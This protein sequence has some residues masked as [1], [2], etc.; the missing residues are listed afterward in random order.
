M[1]CIPKEQSHHFVAGM[2]R[3]LKVYRQSYDLRHP[4]VCMDEMS[5]QQLVAEVRERLPGRPGPPEKYD[6]HYLH[7]EECTL[8]CSASRWLA[9]GGRQ[10]TAHD[11]GLGAAGACAGESAALQ[12]RGTITL[13][14]RQLEHPQR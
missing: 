1:W 9:E 3:V 2:E 5:K 14:W 4:L 11:V 10:R 8:G 13:V 7:R 12:G 6:A